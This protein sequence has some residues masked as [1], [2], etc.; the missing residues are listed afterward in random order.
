[1]V[2]LSAEVPRCQEKRAWHE[3]IA[4]SHAEGARHFTSWIA[5]QDSSCRMIAAFKL[6]SAALVV[7]ESW[8]IGLAPGRTAY[9]YRGPLPLTTPFIK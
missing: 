9:P 8:L 5:L 6:F 3:I 7:K 2:F 1:M 4:T